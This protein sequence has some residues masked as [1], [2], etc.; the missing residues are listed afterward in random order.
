VYQISIIGSLG[1]IKDELE[2][3]PSL[4]ACTAELKACSCPPPFDIDL[5]KNKLHYDKDKQI[6]ELVATIAS[7]CSDGIDTME[8]FASLMRRLSD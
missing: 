7:E 5:K 1:A 4:Q 3:D 6:R 2:K 8:S